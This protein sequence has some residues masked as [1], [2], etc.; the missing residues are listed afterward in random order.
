[1]LCYNIFTQLQTP[2]TLCYLYNRLLYVM[3]SADIDQNADHTKFQGYELNSSLVMAVQKLLFRK[4]DFKSARKWFNSN[5]ICDETIWTRELKICTC[6]L[7]NYVYP[8]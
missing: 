5:P 7:R 8:L 3:I 2:T 4:V 6:P 1:M